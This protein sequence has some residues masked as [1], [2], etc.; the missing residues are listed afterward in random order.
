[1]L[2][3]NSVIILCCARTSATQANGFFPAAH[4]QLNSVF[5]D[6]LDFPP[7]AYRPNARK[8]SPDNPH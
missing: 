8:K 2:D 3:S 5:D 1:M 6:M 7:T 4:L